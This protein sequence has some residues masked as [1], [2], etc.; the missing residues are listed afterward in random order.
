MK[1][2]H[3]RIKLGSTKY[4]GHHTLVDKE[5]YEDL[6]QYTWYARKERTSNTASRIVAEA[7]VRGKYIALSRY[8]MKAKRGQI[9]D[10]INRNPL[11]NRRANLRFVTQS[12]NQHNTLR[13]KNKSG[14]KGI[15]KIDKLGLYKAVVEI[16]GEV[17]Y[18]GYFKKMRDA[19]K[20]YRAFVDKHLK[21]F[22][23][24]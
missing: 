15:Y 18:L 19:V 17:H 4:P 3:K 20:V 6:M 22:A 23:V 11:D 10:H 13:R 5:D 9:V 24:Y 16:D 14:H 12:Q 8:L 1:K 2:P 21:E 7:R